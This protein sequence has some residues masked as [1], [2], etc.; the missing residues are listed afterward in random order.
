VKQSRSLHLLWPALGG[1]RRVGGAIFRLGNGLP[2]SFSP[3]SDARRRSQSDRDVSPA[4]ILAESSHSSCSP[5]ARNPGRWSMS[6]NPVGRR[7]F[8]MGESITGRDLSGQTT[9]AFLVHKW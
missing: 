1:L 2:S 7:P 9:F 4:A 5:V 3:A 6:S 8:P